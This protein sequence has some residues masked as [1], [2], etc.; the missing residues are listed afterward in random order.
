MDS[1]YAWQLESEAK[2]VLDQ[3]GIS[4]F[5]QPM[6]ELSGG[7]RKRVALAGVLV[8][9]SD[10]LILDEP[11]NHMDNETVAWLEQ[12]LLKRKGALLMVTHDRYFFDRVVN[13][14]LELDG[15][16]CYLYT[17]NYSLFLQKREERRQSEAAAAQRLRNVYRR[18]LAWISRGAKTIVIVGGDSALND[19]VNCLMQIDPKEREGAQAAG[20]GLRLC[21]ERESE[22]RRKIGRA[23]V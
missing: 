15:G 5:N 2:A 13:R 1:A 4:D 21:A 16:Q 19:A 10:L 11:T 20:R 9:P 7:Q 17:G 3:L 23:H 12:L 14:T 18:E 22:E 6:A 8:R